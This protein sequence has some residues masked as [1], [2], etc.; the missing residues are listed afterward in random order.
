MMIELKWQ[1]KMSQLMNLRCN[2]CWAR[3]VLELSWSAVVIN[4]KTEGTTT[5][6]DS[7]VTAKLEGM[8]AAGVEDSARAVET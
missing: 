2:L 1:L 3:L 5:K 4:K 6:V 8:M 7:M